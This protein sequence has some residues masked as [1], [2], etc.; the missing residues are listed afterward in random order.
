MKK[1]ACLFITFAFIMAA[2]MAQ[3]QQK[4]SA[5]QAKMHVEKAVKFYTD[6]GKK[7]ALADFSDAKGRWVKGDLYIYV[8]SFEGVVLAN[9]VDQKVIGTKTINKPDVEGKFFRKEAINLAKTKGGGWTDYK[10]K[11]PKTNQIEQKTTYC[12]K[13]EDVVICCGAYK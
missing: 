5:A 8:W 6:V 12:K 2:G 1:L 3:A 9:G 4:A 11:N 10:Y 13:V 7:K